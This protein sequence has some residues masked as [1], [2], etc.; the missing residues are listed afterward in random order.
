MS[1]SYTPPPLTPPA[2]FIVSDGSE[3]ATPRE[4]LLRQLLDSRIPK[5]EREWCAGREIGQ[6]RSLLSVAKCPSCDGSGSIAVQTRSRELV[7]REM[8][9]D[10]GEPEMEGSLYCDDEWEQQQ[11]Q[12][13]DECARLLPSPPF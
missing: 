7:T 8:A 4:E 1:D 2:P 6:L 10:A 9:M 11:C 13:C 12:W 3:Q 5:N